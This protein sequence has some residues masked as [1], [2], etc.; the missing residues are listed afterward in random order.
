MTQHYKH[1][2]ISCSKLA[3]EE[4]LLIQTPDWWSNGFWKL[5]NSVQVLAE[6]VFPNIQQNHRNY[7]WLYERAILAS[8]NGCVNKINEQIQNLLP[9]ESKYFKSFDT[10]TDTVQT[11]L[12][13]TEFLNSLDIPGVLPHNLTLK[14]GTP[15]MLLR[16]LDTPK[17]CNGTRLCTKKMYNY[18]V[19]STILT[20]H[21]RNGVQ[22][23]AITVT[24]SFSFYHDNQQSARPVVSSDR[25][26][27]SWAM[28][29]I[30]TALR[31]LFTCW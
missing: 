3:M 30:R 28:F 4:L 12:Y 1:F 26:Q 9:E 19:E 13:P 14:V 11:V 29:F 8:K 6:K 21:W 7:E 27:P 24:D 17:L 10:V 31:R 20:Y 16:N 2:H 23:Q 5:F 15:V 18:I 22:F 25:Y